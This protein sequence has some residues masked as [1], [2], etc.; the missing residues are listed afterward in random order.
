MSK[1]VP[2]TLTREPLVQTADNDSFMYSTLV[3]FDSLVSPSRLL[4]LELTLAMSWPVRS[5][6]AT[7]VIRI[8]GPKSTIA[9]QSQALVLDG[10]TE[11]YSPNFFNCFLSSWIRSI[12]CFISFS[13]LVALALS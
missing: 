6:M 4:L 1:S 10:R 9:R 5:W 3:L 7:M 12:F 8:A 2:V 13:S 11:T